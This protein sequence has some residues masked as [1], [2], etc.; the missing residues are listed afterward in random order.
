LRGNQIKE[1]YQVLKP[2]IDYLDYSHD[3]AQFGYYFMFNEGDV[4][5]WT[6]KELT[7]DELTIY[8]RF[9]T[10]ISLTL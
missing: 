6:E 9:T 10:V 1:Y 8:R 2:Q 3:E 4:Y 7:E 5:A